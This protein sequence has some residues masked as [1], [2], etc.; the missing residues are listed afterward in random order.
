MEDL[1]TKLDPLYR[2]IEEI[3][4][5]C[6]NKAENLSETDANRLYDLMLEVD[7]IE[8]EYDAANPMDP[9]PS[10]GFHRSV[11]TGGTCTNYGVCF[12]APVGFG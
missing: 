2:Q 11:L 9:C 12:E 1:K 5:G 8:D 3:Y 7:K 4:K 6:D 10:C